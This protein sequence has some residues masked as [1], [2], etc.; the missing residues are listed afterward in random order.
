MYS[1]SLNMQQ[2]A[3]IRST[4]RALGGTTIPSLKA[5]FL[6]LFFDVCF[7]RLDGRVLSPTASLDQ[8]SDRM[9]SLASEERSSIQ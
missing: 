5:A 4:M 1:D 2:R 9:L 6:E 8:V 7:S 3:C